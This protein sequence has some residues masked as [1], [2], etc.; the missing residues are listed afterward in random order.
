MEY[1]SFEQLELPNQTV[2]DPNPS[3][4]LAFRRC[5]SDQV[6]VFNRVQCDDIR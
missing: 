1:E 5:T 6:V 2:T 4:V 3:H